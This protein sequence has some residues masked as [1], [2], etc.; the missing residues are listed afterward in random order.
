MGVLWKS[1]EEPIQLRPRVFVTKEVEEIESELALKVELDLF[2][3]G[4]DELDQPC[5]PPGTSLAPLLPCGR[6]P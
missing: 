4:V 1:V 6:C 2:P 5:D 3:V